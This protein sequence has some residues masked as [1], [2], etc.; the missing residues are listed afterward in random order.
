MESGGF[1]VHGLIQLFITDN[2][3]PLFSAT[4]RFIFYIGT[5]SITMNANLNSLLRTFYHFFFAYF[6]SLIEVNISHSYWPQ[7]NV[8]LPQTMANNNKRRK[9]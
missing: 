9:P 4:Q 2:A 6:E 8:P 5:N 3:D 7:I 1:Q